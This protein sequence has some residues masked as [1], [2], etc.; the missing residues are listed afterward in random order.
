MAAS[1]V[2]GRLV[3]AWPGPLMS[4]STHMA[5]TRAQLSAPPRPPPSGRDLLV[6]IPYQMQWVSE[7][8]SSRSTRS[9]YL[10]YPAPI[11]LF[12]ARLD[13][14]AVLSIARQ[15][16][17]LMAGNLAEYVLEKACG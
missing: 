1:S 9:L 2:G 11:H 5:G 6:A 10:V 13:W 14:S 8:G 7:S 15:E 4:R 3:E 17:Q 16:I 12:R